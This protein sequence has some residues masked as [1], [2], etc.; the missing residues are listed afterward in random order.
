MTSTG[1]QMS[2]VRVIRASAPLPETAPAEFTALPEWFI[3]DIAEFFLFLCRYSVTC[4][5]S[6]AF[7]RFPVPRLSKPRV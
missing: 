2:F 3:E 6:H 4:K 7:V 5:L 1:V